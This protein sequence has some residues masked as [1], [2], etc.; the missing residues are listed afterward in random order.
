MC[1]DFLKIKILYLFLSTLIIYFLFYY[2][3]F[4]HKNVKCNLKNNN[5]Y[6]DF[7]TKLKMC[8]HLRN[9]KYILIFDNYYDKYCDDFNG[10]SL[11]E[12]L[13]LNKN[14]S[15]IYYIINE[16]TNLY[17]SIINS[18]KNKNLIFF[19]SQR[20]FR[21]KL[22]YYLLNSKLMITSYAFPFISDFGKNVPHLKFLHINH[23]IR[24]FKKIM[25]NKDLMILKNIK[26]YLI[27]SSIYEYKLLINKFKFPKKYIYKAGLAR[28]DR[29]KYIKKK[30]FGKKC[31]L[32]SF[33]YRN[34]NNLI[35]ENSLLKKNL[36]NLL[37]N[38]LLISFL[39]ENNIELFYIPHHLDLL[40][41][42]IYSQK[43]FK[44]AKIKDNSILTHLIEKCSLLVTD[45]SSLSFEFMFQNK[46]VLFYLIDINDKKYFEEKKYMNNKKDPIYFG[47]VFSKENKLIKKI[48]Y[49][50]NKKF[51]IGKDLKKKYNSVFFKKNNI[52]KRIAEIITKLIK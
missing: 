37:N 45:F 26:S 17:K 9:P 35:F 27:S 52:R 28:W 38:E 48:I 24:Y 13:L 7:V 8:S 42:K 32:I 21:Q 16:N 2:K 18:N 47:N 12:Y 40:K 31:I 49:Y 43:K 25:D 36:E 34:Y 30:E 4:K 20:E 39:K 19:K 5:N 11:F 50:G 6:K 41:K 10:Y 46:P 22:F 1:Q 23:G 3:K 15:D 14:L 51:K 33:T 44:Y 29:F